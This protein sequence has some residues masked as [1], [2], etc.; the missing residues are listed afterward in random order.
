MQVHAT[1]YFARN[2]IFEIDNSSPSH[3][4]NLE[5]N[6]LVLGEGPAHGIDGRFGSPEKKFN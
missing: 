6:F 5:N 2:V 1:L 4:D 3:S